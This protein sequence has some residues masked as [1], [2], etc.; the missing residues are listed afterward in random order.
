LNLGN[1]A[2]LQEIKSSYRKLARNVWFLLLFFLILKNGFCKLLFV[3]I[4]FSGNFYGS[5]L[6]FGELESVLSS[7]WVYVKFKLILKVW[8]FSNF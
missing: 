4:R 5:C 6:V 8:D 2:S 3:L 1:N 7:Y